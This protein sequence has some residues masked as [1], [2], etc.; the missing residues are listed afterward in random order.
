[1]QLLDPP[2][3]PP[4]AM[5]AR[6]GAGGGQP[7]VALQAEQPERS[8]VALVTLNCEVP[9]VASC[10]RNFTLLEFCAPLYVRG[11]GQMATRESFAETDQPKSRRTRARTPLKACTDYTASK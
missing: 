2:H 7:V 9:Q 3:P 8:A 10:V 11:E 4:G 1:M 5:R 6:S